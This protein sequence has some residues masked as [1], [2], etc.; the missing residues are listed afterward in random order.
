TAHQGLEGLGLRAGEALFVPAGAGGVG[1]FAIQLARARGARVIATASPAN[2]DFLREL[3]AEPLD[4]DDEDLVARVHELAQADGADAAFDIF[5]G[6][7]REQAIA[8]L[9]RGG[10]LLSIAS[11]APEKREGYEIH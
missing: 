3:G 6:E 2:H 9:R 11:P 8:T 5:D 10:R 7:R 1:H 4:Y